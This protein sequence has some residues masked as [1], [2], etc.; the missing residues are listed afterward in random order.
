M[1]R[2]VLTSPLLSASA[3]LVFAQVAMADA[4]NDH[5]EG[6]YGESND[7]AVTQAG[8]ILIAGFPLII[9]LASLLQWRLDKRKDA[10][11]AAAKARLARADAR[12]GW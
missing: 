7:L 10:R 8:F 4:N 5:G 9:L 12:G 11:K 1:T 6:W 3:L 2:R